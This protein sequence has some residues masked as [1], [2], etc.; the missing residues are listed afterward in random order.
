MSN[1]GCTRAT[2]VDSQQ[3]LRQLIL[4]QELAD[5]EKCFLSDVN[6]G[7]DD[8]GTN[9]LAAEDTTQ[10]LGNISEDIKA[11]DLIINSGKKRILVG[12]PPA[13]I[14]ISRG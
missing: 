2:S 12:E 11:R 4:E 3:Y 8:N 5:A 1:S 9:F 6:D 7:L 13:E 10:G 14:S